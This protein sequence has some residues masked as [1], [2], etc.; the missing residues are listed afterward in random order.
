MGLGL[1][2]YLGIHANALKLREQRSAIVA[3]NLANL[4]TPNYKA[5]DI[6]FKTAL[7]QVSGESMT[8]KIDNPRHINSQQMLSSNLTYRTSETTSLD[9]NTVDKDVETTEFAK[10][11]MSYQATLNFLNGNIKTIMT[12][13]RGE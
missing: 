4:D 11:A 10:N 12:A 1:N 2:D 6:D 7:K 8:M 5:R 13:L 3:S 9:G